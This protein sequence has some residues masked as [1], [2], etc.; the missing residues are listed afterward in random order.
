M[1]R[2]MSSIISFFFLAGAA[3]VVAPV[4]A[5]EALPM[6]VRALSGE[7]FSLVVVTGFT[8]EEVK[9]TAGGGALPAVPAMAISSS[10]Y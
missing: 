9:G 5:A 4:V 6:V 10:V 8:E 2:R 3:L 7:N 1:L